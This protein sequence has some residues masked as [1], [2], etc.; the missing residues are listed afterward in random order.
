MLDPGLNR[1]DSSVQHVH[2]IAVCGTAMGALACML[3]DRGMTV[4]GS[5]EKVYPPMSDFLRQQGIVVEE[6]FDG[7]RLERR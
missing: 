1:I 3:K 6:G 7:R 5:D 4:T 2:L